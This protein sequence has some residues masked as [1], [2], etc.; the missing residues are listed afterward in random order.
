MNNVIVI[1]A[2]VVLGA[3]ALQCVLRL[4]DTLA[5]Q[6]HQ[7][8][9]RGFEQKRWESDLAREQLKLQR[10]ASQSEHGWTGFRKFQVQK[11]VLEDETKQIC[12]FYL[13]PHDGRPL[14]EFN[15]G[16][17][18]TFSLDVPG[19]KKAVVR[20]YSLSDGPDSDY[21]R[22]SIKRVPNGISSNHFHDNIHE[23]DIVDVRAP[24]GVFH[25]NME[26]N[27]PI[28]LIAGGVG[29]T[30][31]MSMMNAV[32]RSGSDRQ[33]ALF[34]AVKDVNEI[35]M[36]EHLDRVNVEYPNVQVHYCCSAP[37]EPL[38]DAPNFH[39]GRLSTDLMG[40]ILGSSNFDYYMC[41]PP[42]MME[43]MK[44]A[45]GEWGVP[46]EHVHYEAFGGAAI[47]KPAPAD[48]GAGGKITFSR[49]GKSLDWDASAGTLLEF[50]E[51]NDIAM[52][53]ACRAGNCGSCM[54]AIREGKVKYLKD[55]EFDDLQ[56][57]SV[58]PCICQPDGDITLDA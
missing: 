22:V 29:I 23:G 55:P 25:I 5:R 50:V 14:P 10:A 27:F 44:K 43:G 33:V 4:L 41:G 32:I 20:C 57:G 31:C 51:D 48:A 58:L 18:L 42:P 54:T 34:Y 7:A 16:Q 30:P 17:F 15:P 21:Y 28:V 37:A 36:R 45:L 47:P 24:N 40:Q 35:A 8:K 13:F 12:S 52:D 49:S 2:L 56:E 53:C 26:D 9:A 6:K 3:L 38:P 1:L 46:K 39:E 11:K 19:Q